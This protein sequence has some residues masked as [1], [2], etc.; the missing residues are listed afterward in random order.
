M[1]LLRAMAA[2]FAMYSRLPVPP[3]PWSRETLSWSLVCFPAVG[4]VLG[5][6]FLAW[7]ALCRFLEAGALFFAAGATLLP[8]LYTGG[9]HLDGFCD[10]CDALGSHQSSERKLEIMK[11]SH[12]GAFAVM[13]C[14][15]YLLTMFSLWGQLDRTWEDCAALASVFPLSRALSTWGALTLP[16]ARRDG[17]LV[18]FT[19]DTAGAATRRAA[20]LLAFLCAALCGL[21]GAG[22][23]AVAAG[24][25]VFFWYRRL[26]LGQFGGVTGDTSGF[27]LQLCEGACLLAVVLTQRVVDVLL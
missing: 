1:R 27:F 5:G 21:L 7:C 25:A 15:L 22:M 10:T 4:A 2:C 24:G 23:A 14:T 20:L 12:V 19:Q 16:K 26:A 9:I 11:D 6:L 17:L 8:V 13:G 3:V 18:R